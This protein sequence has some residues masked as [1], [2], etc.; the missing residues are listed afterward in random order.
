MKNSFKK[1]LSVFLVSYAHLECSFKIHTKKIQRKG[2]NFR[3]KVQKFEKK[4]MKPPKKKHFIQQNDCLN[5]WI[6]VLTT[7]PECFQQKPEIFCLIIRK[8]KKTL[9]FPGKLF[10]AGNFV[11][12]RRMRL[13]ESC[14]KILDL[15]LRIVWSISEKYWKIEK[16]SNIFLL[17]IIPMETGLDIRKFSLKKSNQIFR[18]TRR[19]QFWQPRPIFLQKMPEML[20]SK[21]EH[22]RTIFFSQQNTAMFLWTHWMQLSNPAENLWKKIKSLRSLPGK[23]KKLELLPKNVFFF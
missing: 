12:T 8:V 10:S 15:V 20:Q 9:S 1:T 13:S 4:T 18:W 2:E 23:E 17:H 14:R 7:T 21:S 3:L 6:A 22:D 19:M 5:T 16:L 11:W